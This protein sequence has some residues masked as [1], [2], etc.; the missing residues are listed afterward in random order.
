M[1]IEILPLAE[2]HLD[3]A[4]VRRHSDRNLD[5][6]KASLARFG[7]QKPV[8]IGKGNVVIAGNGTVEAARALGW[9]DIQAVRT[10][11]EGS[12]AVGY[13][14]ADNRS[15]ELADWDMPSLNDMLGALAEDGVDLTE[16][17]WDDADLAAIEKEIGDG[18]ELTDPP[19]PDTPAEP[20]TKPGDLYLLGAHRL[21]C[22][23]ATKA[24]DVK[25]L[26]GDKQADACVT[27]PPYGVGIDYGAFEDTKENVDALIQKI[28]PF[29]LAVPCAALTPGV[30]A[31]WSY[32]RPTWVGAWIHPAP[33]GG[34]PWG[35]VGNN[36]ILFY[37]NDPYLKAGKGRRP[38]SIVMASDRQ[39]EDGHPTPKPIKVWA[40]LVERLT[41]EAGQI[42]FD[43]FLGSGTT[44]VA[45][46]NLGRTGYGIEINPGYCDVVLERMK[47]LG[48]TPRLVK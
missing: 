29:I 43:P 36:P 4:N 8:V 46:E 38:D 6:I 20:V 16:L 11:L 32:P 35:F 10:A 27:D 22:G 14:L 33:C 45:C 30:P 31:M 23:D 18:R 19:V 24:E 41:P 17:G 12:E 7:Q 39:G 15:A 47:V 37:G 25:R 5:A 21:L 26:M 9:T 28:M 40:W 34:C 1:Q 2:I 48:L 42:V 44:L 13:A 3:P